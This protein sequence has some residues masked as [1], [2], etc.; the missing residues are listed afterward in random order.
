MTV[1]C[2]PRLDKDVMALRPLN[3]STKGIES[4]VD[5]KFV[6]WI[7]HTPIGT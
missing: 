6:T 3:A 5:V 4:S 1:K 2:W 7:M